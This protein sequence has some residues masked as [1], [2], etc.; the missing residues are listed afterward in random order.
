[1]CAPRASASSSVRV[2]PVDPV[3][4][5]AQPSEVAQV[6]RRSG[7]AG[8]L[9]DRATSRQGGWRPALLRVRP[10][11]VG[12]QAPRGARARR[13]RPGTGRPDAEDAA[14]ATIRTQRAGLAAAFPVEPRGLTRQSVPVFSPTIERAA[15]GQDDRG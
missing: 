13:R 15:R 7:S 9:R 6:L 3:A 4:G 5:T 14:I 8:H 10:G 12:H 1:M 2:L 11:P